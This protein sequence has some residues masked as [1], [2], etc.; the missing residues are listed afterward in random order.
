MTQIT[1]R[2]IM[3]R[4]ANFGYN[5]E[6]AENNA[7]QKEKVGLSSKEITDAAIKEFDSF[8][9]LLRSNGIQVQVI[10]DTKSPIKPDAIFPNNWFTTHAD[11]TIITYPMYAEVRRLERREDVIKDLESRSPKMKRYGFEY[12]ENENKFLEGTGSMILDR[13]NKIVYAC[14]SPRTN[15]E[16]LDK[17]SILKGYQAVFFTALDRTGGEIYHTNVMMTMGEK[18][19]LICLESIKNEEEKQAL[20][21]MF[22]QTAKE[23]IDIN[24]DQMESFAGNMIQLKNSVE[25]RFVIMSRQARKALNNEQI[26]KIQKHGRIISPDIITIENT[27]GGSARCMIAE[28]FLPF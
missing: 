28:D 7:F 12:F 20:V 22:K 9:D 3:V 2:I 16:I 25:D 17:F 21:K 14:L 6:T 8:V 18:F 1:D 23:I 4:P 19:V 11:G 27:G 13:E 15:I 26:S 5:L 24:Y 10:E